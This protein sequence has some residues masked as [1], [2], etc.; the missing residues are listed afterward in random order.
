MLT[1]AQC[2]IIFDNDGVLVNSSEEHYLTFVALGEEAGYTI[3]REQFLHL[4]GRHNRDIFPILF[5]HQL[6]V[7]EIAALSARKEELFRAMV[8][9]HV[10]ALPGVLALLPALRAAGFHLA[11]GTS[12]PR[13]NLDLILSELG[14]AADF[15][16]IAS[17]EDV[18]RGKPD[19]QVFLIAAERLGIA[20]AHCVVVEDAVAGV[21][22]ACAGG[23]RALAVTTNH[24]RAALQQA[25][26]VVDSL[27]EVGPADFLALLQT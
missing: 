20:P 3:T 10:R 6:P 14:I 21:Q 18:T 13:D 4:F 25:D 15:E 5:G 16:A 23:M 27:T 9:G 8:R 19:P 12:T 26:R 17:A 24:T 2:G 22:A 11:V 1:P 7:E